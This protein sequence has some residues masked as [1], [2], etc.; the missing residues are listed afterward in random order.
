MVSWTLVREIRG[1]ELITPSDEVLSEGV[2]FCATIT[3]EIKLIQAC[4]HGFRRPNP[5]PMHIGAN[6]EDTWCFLL[7]G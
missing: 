4:G 6:N 7:A 5:V 1:L 3:P 2:F